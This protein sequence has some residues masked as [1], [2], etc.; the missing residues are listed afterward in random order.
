M[1]GSRSY[2]L[3][4][5]YFEQDHVTDLVQDEENILAN[6]IGSHLY[7]VRLGVGEDGLDYDCSCPVGADGSFC[8][9]CVAVGLEW[10]AKRQSGESADTMDGVRAY[11]ESLDKAELVRM[12]VEQA[13]ND[14]D[15]RN[16][17]LL[18][19]A[20]TAKGGLDATAL[21][22][23]IARA[24]TIRGYLEYD[25]VQ[26]YAK[27]LRN[28]AEAISKVLEAGHA[29]EAADLAQYA[30]VQIDENCE[31]AED[32]DG[33]VSNVRNDLVEIHRAADIADITDPQELANHLFDL[34]M[35]S[36]YASF[37]IDEYTEALGEVGM[38]EYR[39]AVEEAWNK[40]PVFGPQEQTPYRYGRRHLLESLM[41]SYAKD[42][43]D[44]EQT[45]RI[46]TRDLSNS[47]PVFEHRP[48]L[49]AG[50]PAYIRAI[51][52]R[53][54]RQGVSRRPAGSL[55]RISGRRVPTLGTPRR[56]TRD[57]LERVQ[58]FPL[59]S[60][61]HPAPEL[62]GAYWALGRVARQGVETVETSA[63]R[64]ARIADGLL[65]AV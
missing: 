8:K 51:V 25:E 52:G 7:R 29:A 44:V 14:A 45:V 11:L 50:G 3:G 58:K 55:E 49:R 35:A 54:G 63:G 4:K 1:A 28:I 40:L 9:H 32:S 6:V 43:G 18:H 34:Q 10:L 15:F 17:L 46:L 62:C 56:S 42:A 48:S 13:L 37:Q 65:Y 53:R 5:Q 16:R 61:L 64:G 26:A 19:L 57:P 2:A 12:L 27:G 20:Q 38:A 22:A 47:R 33:E 21:R 36:E 60:R 39:R 59:T 23:S 24:A 30:I 31:E 41:L